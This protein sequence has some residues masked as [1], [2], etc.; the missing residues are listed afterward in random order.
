MLFEDG[1]RIA[2]YFI[3]LKEEMETQDEL[4]KVSGVCRDLF[5]KADEYYDNNLML[6]PLQEIAVKELPDGKHDI[7]LILDGI[8]EPVLQGVLKGLSPYVDDGSY[9]VCVDDDLCF[10]K[11]LKKNDQWKKIPGKVVFEE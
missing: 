10:Y 8:C 1:L 4:K 6:S 9:L 2:E 5:D 11:F 7:G 3:P